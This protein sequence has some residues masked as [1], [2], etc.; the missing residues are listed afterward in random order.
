[1]Y[2]VKRTNAR[3][4]AFIDLVRLLDIELEVRDGDD[5][6]FYD[7]F[8]KLDKI[9]HA[10]VISKEGVPLGCGALKEFKPLTI[11]IKRMFVLEEFRGKGVA[12]LILNE[13]ETWAAELSYKYCILETG[14]NQPEA[15]ALYHKNDYK[16]I[17]NYGQYKG[18]DTSICFRKEL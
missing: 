1:M 17:T 15:I 7:Q 18:V 8:N 4:P 14:I 3:D 9:K 13:L 5:H 11:E 12:T 10:V 16:I 6:P 2:L